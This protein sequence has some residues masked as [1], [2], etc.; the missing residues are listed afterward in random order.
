[1]WVACLEVTAFAVGGISAWCLLKNRHVPFFLKSFKIAVIAAIVVT[2]LQI[3]LGDGSGRTVYTHQPEKLAAIE[4]HWNTNKPGE[5]APWKLL[6]WP[7]T[8][9]QNNRWEIKIPYALSIITTHSLTGEVKGLKDFQRDMQPPIV[10]PFYAFRVMILMGF[11]LFF[12]MLITVLAW[13]RGQLTAE[14]I[15]NHRGM[16][17]AWMAAL[18]LSFVAMETG[19]LTREVGRQPWIIYGMLRTAH[20]SSDL[21]A[22]A[23]AASLVAFTS[24]YLVLLAVCLF[25]SRRIIMKG[26]DIGD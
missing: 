17:Y 18:P 13:Y 14:Q 9:E 23:V 15:K 22:N 4:A 12:L 20:A 6:A 7:D 16:L 26:P 11:F 1:M 10:L 8:A 24:I 19:W 3:Y 25:F 21:P 2:P 5:G